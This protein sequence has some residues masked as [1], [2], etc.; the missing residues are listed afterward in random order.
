MTKHRCKRALNPPRAYQFEL[1]CSRDLASTSARH[2]RTDPSLEP[3]TTRS[4]CLRQPIALIHRG[5]PPALYPCAAGTSTAG[6]FFMA[7]QSARLP[8]SPPVVNQSSLSILQASF[9]SETHHRKHLT[10]TANTEIALNINQN[11]TI[12]TAVQVDGQ[13][14]KKRLEAG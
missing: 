1:T 3:L 12:N 11:R 8:S 13:N 14:Y 5:M 6:F 4:D 10:I 2:S 7:N 9:E